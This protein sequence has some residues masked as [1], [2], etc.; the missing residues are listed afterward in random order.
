MRFPQLKSSPLLVEFALIGVPIL[1][2]GTASAQKDILGQFLEGLLDHFYP[3]YGVQWYLEYDWF[4]ALA[5]QQ[6]ITPQ[7]TKESLDTAGVQFS[8]PSVFHEMVSLNV[9]KFFL[10]RILWTD[11]KKTSESLLGVMYYKK[12]VSLIK[13]V[14][15]ISTS[16]YAWRPFQ[17]F[18]HNF[19]FALQ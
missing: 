12:E 15:M 5:N 13:L 17:H 16:Y 19:R 1:R 7:I 8:E 4:L 6:Y 18:M 11:S 2:K 3:E 14:K 10:S 9:Y